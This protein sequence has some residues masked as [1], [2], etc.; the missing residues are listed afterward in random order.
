V[1]GVQSLQWLAV[2]I[3]LYICQ[4][5]AE[6]LRSQLYQIPVSKHFLVST[7]VSG[8][9][10]YIWDGSPGRAASGWPFLSLCSTLCLH[11]SSREYM[12]SPN[13]KDLSIHTLAFLLLELHVV[14]ELS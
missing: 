1:L 6:P 7:I 11:I 2:S 14:C 5:L 13:K 8:F 10:D 12:V 4:A 9:S 3:H